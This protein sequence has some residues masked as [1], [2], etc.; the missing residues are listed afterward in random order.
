MHHYTGSVVVGPSNAFSFGE[1]LMLRSK[2][3]HDSFALGVCVFLTGILAN[4]VCH[5]QFHR[6]LFQIDV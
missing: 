3:S 4:H 5:F 6:N 1:K 2:T